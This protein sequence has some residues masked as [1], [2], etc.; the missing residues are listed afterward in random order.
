MKT[1]YLKAVSG[2][3]ALL[4]N[5]GIPIIGYI[6]TKKRKTLK[7]DFVLISELIF[8]FGNKP[9]D[10]FEFVDGKLIHFLISKRTP[11]YINKAYE[12]CIFKENSLDNFVS[13]VTSTYVF[14]EIG[15]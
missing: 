13:K 10:H 3:H 8:H 12:E 14:H 5:N 1:K 2:N 11:E 7:G 4:K 6:E 9:C 15:F